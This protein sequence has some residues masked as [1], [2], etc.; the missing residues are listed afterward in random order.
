MKLFEHVRHVTACGMDGRTDEPT[1][2]S[3]SR[4][5]LR[6]SVSSPRRAVTYCD[7]FSFACRS[8]GPAS[9]RPAPVCAL[10]RRSFRCRS[11]RIIRQSCGTRRASRV[12]GA[13]HHRSPV[14]EKL[15]AVVFMK[16]IGSRTPLSLVLETSCNAVL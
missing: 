14:N 11:R 10:T 5:S 16:T 12:S 13:D 2:T 15:C 6:H 4:L 1:H 9:D 3:G 7:D 8:T